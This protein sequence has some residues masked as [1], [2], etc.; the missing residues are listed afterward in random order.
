MK[1]S[2][3]LLL[4]RLIEQPKLF[5]K[6]G[7]YI[8]PEDF[9]E[10]IY[11]RA[12]ALLFAQYQE[13][14]TVNPARIVSMFVNEEEQREIAG[15]FNARIQQIETKD[16]MEKALKE[17]IVRV[18][19]NSIDHRELANDDLAGL[20]RTSSRKK[21]AGSAGKDTYFHRFVKNEGNCEEH[22]MKTGNKDKIVTNYERMKQNGKKE[23]KYG[24]ECRQ[25]GSRESK[26]CQT[27][28]SVQ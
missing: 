19:K 17:T 9:T 8:S 23:R 10:E 3:K 15:L 4:T 22:G 21:E 1:Q 11:H 18:K 12:A 25:G 2:Q 16:D 26:G 14:G 7:S 24:K 28:A 27:D 5:D 20:M 6:I 13:S